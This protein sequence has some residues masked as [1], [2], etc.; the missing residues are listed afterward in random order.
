LANSSDDTRWLR[1]AAAL[2]VRARPLSRPNPAVGAILVKG[3]V[4]VGR[5]WTAAGGRPHAEAIALEQAGAAAGEATLYVTLE[6]C[7]HESP[8]GPCCADLLVEAGIDRVVVGVTD[9]DPRTA[10]AGAARLGAAGIAAVLA[11]DDACRASLAGY[12]T[13]RGKRRPFVTLKL[14]VTADGFI[15]RK[16]G[17]SKWITG[18]PARA[19]A[20]VERAMSDAILVGGG[21]LRAD[22]PGLDVRLPGLEHRSPRRFVLTKGEAP[23]G[24]EAISDS[25][26]LPEVQYLLIEGGSA[27]AEAFLA[28]GLV[29]RLLLYRAPVEFG[30]GIP[31]F[32]DGMPKGYE[33]TDRRQLGSDTLEVYQRA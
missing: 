10:G 8:R 11:D 19:H 7:A 14:A 21:T 15:A 20:H 1:A 3:G 9:P 4:V 17:T 13:L 25:H 33:L 24:W 18:E 6:P 32:R 29:D 26:D 2:A 22:A 12:L 23:D 30:E 28:A 27:S 16:D 5:G 31:A